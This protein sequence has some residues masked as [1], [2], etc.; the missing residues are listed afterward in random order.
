MSELYKVVTGDVLTGNEMFS[1]KVKDS[2]IEY[3]YTVVNA[4]PRALWMCRPDG[5]IVKLKASAKSSDTNALIIVHS[6]FPGENELAWI[7]GYEDANLRKIAQ[8][9]GSSRR[10]EWEEKISIDEIVRHRNGVYVKSCD[11]V[12]TA[13][14]VRASMIHHPKCVQKIH[15]DYINAITTEGMDDFVTIGIRLVDNSGT[16]GTMYTVLNDKVQ[17]LNPI[18]DVNQ[19]DGLYVTG[20]VDY[21]SH[22]NRTTRLDEWYSIEDVRDNKAPFQLYGSIRE[23]NEAKNKEVVK[24]REMDD[25][26]HKRE[27]EKEMAKLKFENEKFILELTQR[28]KEL[29]ATIKE[30]EAEFSKQKA[31]RDNEYHEAKHKRNMES[32]F[33]QAQIDSIK[34]TQEKIAN[35]N[36]IFLETIKTIGIIVT[37]ALTIKALISKV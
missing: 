5:S 11:I 10:I 12:I 13:D 4:S 27:M 23:A 9:T 6:T 14:S 22:G 31:Y 35:D 33:Y 15:N 28:L 21:D 26:A 29:D 25:Q 2:F 34:A 1:H 17:R 18:H 19:K 36:K 16:I 30:K 20:F 8:G 7:E 3:R 32:E 37:G 24:I